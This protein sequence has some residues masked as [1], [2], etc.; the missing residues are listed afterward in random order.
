MAGLPARMLT[1]ILL[2][3][4]LPSVLTS[5][6]WY[7]EN[8]EPG[9]DIMIMDLRWPWWAESTYSANWNIGILPPGVTAYGGFA[10]SVATI[11]KDHR[12]IG[13]WELPT[14]Q[15]Q[16]SICLMNHTIDRSCL[17]YKHSLTRRHFRT[18]SMDPTDIPISTQ[19]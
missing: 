2:A 10:G 16:L 9:A 3:V 19:C 14:N 7:G 5:A 12:P 4:M 6:R 18:L 13:T 17:S 8:V 11:G 1:S 15:I